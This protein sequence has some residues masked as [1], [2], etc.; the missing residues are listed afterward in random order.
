MLLSGPLLVCRW[1]PALIALY[2][3]D[4][5]P[6]YTHV[7]SNTRPTLVV[8]AFIQTACSLAFI[9]ASNRFGVTKECKYF[10]NCWPA[11]VAAAA[12]Q[13]DLFHVAVDIIYQQ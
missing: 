8:D 3:A 10:P 7:N 11:I 2:C 13:R 9:D 4:G 6:F 12:N 5:S 1:P